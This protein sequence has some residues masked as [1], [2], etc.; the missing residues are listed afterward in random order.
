MFI[1]AA[2]VAVP[3]NHFSSVCTYFSLI[4]LISCHTDTQ[5]HVALDLKLNTCRGILVMVPQCIRIIKLLILELL[6]GLHLSHEHQ[7]MAL[8]RKKKKKQQ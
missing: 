6:L 2:Q 8:S 4:L 3:G 5:G 7:E 1:M